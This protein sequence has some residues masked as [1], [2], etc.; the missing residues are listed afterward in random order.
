MD[1]CAVWIV[2]GE[3]ESGVDHLDGPV[4]DPQAEPRGVGERRFLGEVLDQ[5]Q[6]LVVGA[7]GVL[8]VARCQVLPVVT[9]YDSWGTD[10]T[11]ASPDTTVSS[12]SAV[13]S[14]RTRSSPT[15]STTST[16]AVTVS[17]GYTGFSKVRSWER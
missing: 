8:D 5:V 3:F 4:D 2:V 15:S 14:T 13:V 1:G 16:L 17:P 6:H 10:S 11:T 9:G 12:V 7:V